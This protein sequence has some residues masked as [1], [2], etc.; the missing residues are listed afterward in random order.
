MPQNSTSSYP[1]TNR[2]YRWTLKE[3]GPILWGLRKDAKGLSNAARYN[4]EE[5]WLESKIV[6]PFV[7]KDLPICFKLG[8]VNTISEETAKL[9]IRC[10]YRGNLQIGQSYE[11]KGRDIVLQRKEHAFHILSK[12]E[13]ELEKSRNKLVEQGIVP[14]N[15]IRTMEKDFARAECLTDDPHI[16]E[17]FKLF[18]LHSLKKPVIEITLGKGF[19]IDQ[20]I[21]QIASH[22]LGKKG[23]DR[24]EFEDLC[25]YGEKKFSLA[26]TFNN[27]KVDEI[28]KKEIRHFAT[29][30]RAWNQHRGIR[31]M[32]YIENSEEVLSEIPGIAEMGISLPGQN[33]LVKPIHIGP[34]G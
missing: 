2:H 5:Y 28:T 6:R 3:K 33:Q 20:A 11:L 34:K 18:S 19:S 4:A 16:L 24:K 7:Q 21:E 14:R 15:N 26:V 27:E 12:A 23:V 31:I 29:L 10:A 30:V 25:I 9:A 1:V 22:V 13:L 17:H 32:A 8:Q